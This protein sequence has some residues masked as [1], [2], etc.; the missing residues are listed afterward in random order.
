MRELHWHAKAAERAFVASGRVRT[1]V[2]DR[3]GRSAIDDFSPGDIRCFPR[4]R[5]HVLQCLGDE[6]CHFILVFDALPKHDLFISG[7]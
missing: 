1:T 5:G 2:V 7:E 3:Q 4:G 6:P